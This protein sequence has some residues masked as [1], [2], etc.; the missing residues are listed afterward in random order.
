VRVVTLAE[1]YREWWREKLNRALVQATAGSGPTRL[2]EDV[3][4][5]ATRT[6][7]SR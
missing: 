6:A 1:L 5:D 3:D 4:I 7:H 2:F